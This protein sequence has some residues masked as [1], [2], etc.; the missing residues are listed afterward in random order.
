MFTKV[1]MKKPYY[2]TKGKYAD[3][4][5]RIVVETPIGKGKKISC[6]LP[7]P[8]VIL[9]LLGHKDLDNYDKED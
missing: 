5:Q 3:G 1:K 2:R 4:R 9:K 8:E 6:A 7:K